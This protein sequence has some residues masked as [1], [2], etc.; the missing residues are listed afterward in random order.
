MTGALVMTGL[1]I[2]GMNNATTSAS[3]FPTTGNPRRHEETRLSQKAW[4]GFLLGS[5]YLPVE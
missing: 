3:D 4:A 2:T 5:S 1:V